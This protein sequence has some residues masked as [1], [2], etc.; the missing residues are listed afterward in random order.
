MDARHAEGTQ[1]PVRLH[2][3]ALPRHM[4]LLQEQVRG[5]E[6]DAT[7]PPARP[8]RSSSLRARAM[9]CRPS[10]SSTTSRP[11]TR[12][13]P[14]KGT[15]SHY[16][17]K[18]DQVRSFRS[19]RPRRDRLPDLQPGG[20][21]E[22]G[23]EHGQG[24]AM[25]KSWTG[26]AGDRGL[27][28]ATDHRGLGLEPSPWA[29]GTTAGIQTTCEKGSRAN[30]R[31]VALRGAAGLRRPATRAIARGRN[32]TKFRC[33]CSIGGRFSSP[34]GPY[35]QSRPLPLTAA[36]HQDQLHGRDAFEGMRKAGPARLARVGPAGGAREAGRHDRTARRDWSSLSRRA[37]ALSLHRS[38]T[39][40]FQGDLHIESITLSATAF[41]TPSR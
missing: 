24:E 33:K 3:A 18:G 14:P 21:A 37:R 19:H 41:P 34:W 26:P 23:R 22:D 39:A 17:N 6:P 2:P 31:Y 30:L 25:P 9:T 35:E 5:Q 20:H 4:E 7:S 13:G 15:I 29:P 8:R 40:A 28:P 27:L 16:P 36:R 1:G 11:G 32:C 38:T 12:S 10:S